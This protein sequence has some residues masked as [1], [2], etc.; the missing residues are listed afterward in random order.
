ME[1]VKAISEYGVLIVIAGL[2]IFLV[3]A[4]IREGYKIMN[5]FLSDLILEFKETNKNIAKQNKNMETALGNIST[6]LEIIKNQTEDNADLFKL[7]D[8][9]AES[10]NEKLTEVCTVVR[11]CHKN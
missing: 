11:N 1:Y 5:K 9:R 10:M 3:V 4:G 7:H 8:R 2:S 6:S